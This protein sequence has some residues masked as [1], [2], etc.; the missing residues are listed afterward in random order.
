[1]APEVW[2]GK[3]Y[4]KNCD[5]YSFAVVLYEMIAL[6][7]AFAFCRDAK[8]VEEFAEEV[9][10]RNKRPELKEV[11]APPSIKELLPMCWHGIPEYRCDMSVLSAVL[12]RELMLLRKGDES[13]LP[14]FTQRRSTFIFALPRGNKS[15]GGSSCSGSFDLSVQSI[16]NSSPHR[17]RVGS[18]DSHSSSI[19]VNSVFGNLSASFHSNK[20]NKKSVDINE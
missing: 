13:R 12:R 1:M 6:K 4:N 20:S 19:K 5:V 14:D 10:V 9:F 18:F 7:R 16:S 15:R 11:R 3:P 2:E 8:T 17:P